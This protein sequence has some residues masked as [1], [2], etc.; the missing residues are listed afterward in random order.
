[1]FIF[2][3]VIKNYLNL[4]FYFLK[5]KQKINKIIKLLTHFIKNGG[6]DIRLKGA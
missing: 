3:R 4:N 2:L 6:F 5:L 1:M